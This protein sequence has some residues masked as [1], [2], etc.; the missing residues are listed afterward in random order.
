MI[1]KIEENTVALQPDERLD[2]INENLRLIQKI[3]GLTFGTDA[4]LLSAFAKAMPASSVVDLGSG[5]GVASLLC[6]SRGKYSRAHAVEIQHAFCDLIERNAALN[7]MEDRI[8]VL[9]KDVRELTQADI[10][11]TV[12]AVI[13]NP[14]YM[15]N[16]AGLSS[17]TD[18]MQ[19]ARRE[20]NGTIR[21]FCAAAARLLSTG[22]NFYTVFRP[23][24]LPE[25]ISALRDVK[26]EPK[27]MVTVYPDA[28]S[29]PCL[30]LIESKK[31]AAPSLLY[32]P[33]LV[34]YRSPTERVYTNT[35]ARVYN[36]FSLEF[37]FSTKKGVGV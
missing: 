20:C 22:G 34:I 2:A 1:N 13:S 5:T 17:A 19:I 14:P 32:A 23:D 8:E 16:G 15:V 33:P 27:R 21:D 9:E 30:V 26:L 6:L 10:G 31:D 28:E 12:S 35:M 11:G 7:G 3:G 24:R 37:L 4:Y 29:R 36:T 18:E 25:L